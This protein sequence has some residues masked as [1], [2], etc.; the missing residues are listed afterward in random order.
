MLARLGRE[1]KRALDQVS[2]IPQRQFARQQALARD[3]GRISPAACWTYAAV[4]LTGTGPDALVRL[5]DGL[6]RLERFTRAFARDLRRQQ[7][8]DR[9][10]AFPD[11]TLSEVP[12]L[13]VIP[14]TPRQAIAGALPDLLLLF[15]FNLVFFMGA[16]LRV[17]SYDAR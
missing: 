6:G 5:N 13:R 9:S 14:A 8:S 15:I 10:R 16:Y 17:L 3:L 4:A 2:R 12:R 1:K 7:A 11:F